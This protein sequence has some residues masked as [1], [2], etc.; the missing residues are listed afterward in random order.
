MRFYL[1]FL[2]DLQLVFGWGYG[3]VSKMSIDGGLFNLFK[4]HWPTWH[5][6]RHESGAMAVGTPDCNVCATPSGVETWLELKQTSGW[7]VRVRPAQVAWV[8]RR[9]RAGGRVLVAVRRLSKAPPAK[10]ARGVAAISASAPVDAL[11]VVPG[12]QIRALQQ[13]GLKATRPLLVTEG[14]PKAWDWDA[15]QR[16]L[17]GGGLNPP[18]VD[19]SVCSTYHL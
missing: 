4:A 15:L 1:V 17:T 13:G 14:G 12:G 9:A 16:L 6:T 11:W 8:D 2:L 18:Q 5:W 7:A 19:A 3:L 10:A